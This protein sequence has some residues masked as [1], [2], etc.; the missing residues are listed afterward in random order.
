MKKLITILSATLFVATL[1]CGC[2][3][4]PKKVAYKT[5]ASVG[6]AGDKAASAV[7]AGYAHNK[8]TKAQFE[9]AAV[10]Y[11]QFQLAYNNA[12]REAMYSIDAKP[13]DAI[14]FILNDWLMF[15]NTLKL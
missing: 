3:T 7:A 1:L 9:E 10:K 6:A 15:V 4:T 14:L 8:I 5:L 2:G 11:A 13:D 12:V